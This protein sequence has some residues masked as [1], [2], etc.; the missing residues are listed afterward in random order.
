MKKK[1]YIVL[2]IAL[3]ISFTACANVSVEDGEKHESSFPVTSGSTETETSNT[4]KTTEKPT[5]FPT[6]TLTE[7]PT[8]APTDPPTEPPTEPPRDPRLVELEGLFSKLGFNNWYN[9]ALTSFY[10]SPEKINLKKFFNNGILGAGGVLLTQEEKD[11]VKQNLPGYESYMDLVVLPAEEMDRVLQ[12]HFGIGLSDF[13]PE[14]F[15]MYYLESKSSWVLCASDMEACFNLVFESLEERSDGSIAIDYIGN[16]R[17]GTVV[18][19]KV[20]YDF[21]ILSNLSR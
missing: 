6:E 14:D 12:Q 8:E 11:L 21:R 17:K 9:L 10:D 4:E 5:E 16:G 7:I 15:N 19:L 1:L 13:H 2:L 18:I 20:G 3:L